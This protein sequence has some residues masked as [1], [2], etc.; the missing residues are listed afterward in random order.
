MQKSGKAIA[1]RRESRRGG[2]GRW[3]SARAFPLEGTRPGERVAMQSGR[4]L[5]LCGQVREVRRLRR[6]GR[7]TVLLARFGHAAAHPGRPHN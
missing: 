4:A 6:W 2:V 1:A 5:L 3:S 7:P